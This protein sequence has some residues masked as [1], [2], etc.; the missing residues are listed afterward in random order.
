MD[1][2]RD[3]IYY[4]SKIEGINLRKT[5]DGKENKDNNKITKAYD[6]LINE[7]EINEDNLFK[8]AKNI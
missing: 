8:I 5:I 1:N 3:E 7:E 6:Y 2:K 4:S